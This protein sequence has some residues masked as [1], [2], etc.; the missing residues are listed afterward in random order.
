MV[1]EFNIV[2]RLIV[3]FSLIG[4]IIGIIGYRQYHGDEIKMVIKLLENY[5]EIKNDDQKEMK[6]TEKLGDLFPKLRK[7]LD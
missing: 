3:M 4:C 2:V 7:V 1:L 5:E 6:T